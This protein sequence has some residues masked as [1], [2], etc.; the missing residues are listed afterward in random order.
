[1]FSE[2]GPRLREKL[3]NV[4]GLGPETVDSILLYA[5]EMPFFVIDAYTRRIFS[6]HRWFDAKASYAVLQDYFMSQQ[7]H[8][9]QTFNEYHALIVKTAKVHCKKQ[10]DCRGCPLNVFPFFL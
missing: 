7:P 3:L 9:V 2:P 5:G 10:A 4:K 1:M 8:H 6:R